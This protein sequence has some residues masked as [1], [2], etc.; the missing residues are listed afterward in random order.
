VRGTPA[1][2]TAGPELTHVASRQTIGAG[3]LQTTPENFRTWLDRHREIK[4]GN[5]MPEYEFL[6]AAE[7]EA[8]ATYLEALE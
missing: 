5:L 2:G 7:R 8:I 6:S 3:I 1:E 4:P